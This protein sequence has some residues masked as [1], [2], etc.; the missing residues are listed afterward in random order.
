MRFNLKLI[1]TV[2][3]AVILIG[4]ASALA[5]AA[6][7]VPRPS[8]TVDEAKLSQEVHRQLMDLPFFTVFDNLQYRVDGTEVTLFGQTANPT[9][10]SDARKSIADI[11]S[12]TK[13]NNEIE[14]LPESRFDD[15]IRH[16]EFRAIYSQPTLQKYGEGTYP[17]IHIIV[18]NGHVT[19]MGA[20]NNDADKKIAG[21]RALQ[22]KNVLSVENNLVVR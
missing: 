10:T 21:T 6:K 20:V 1:R 9:L 2:I 13:V 4:A 14:L 17:S 11:Q 3:A 15:R 8:E 22:V 5:S 18:K 16:A 19:L 12:V 7:P